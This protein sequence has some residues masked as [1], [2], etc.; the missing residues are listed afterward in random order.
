MGVA[1]PSVSILASWVCGGVA[2]TVRALVSAFLLEGAVQE[3]GGDGSGNRFSA[4]TGSVG[5][6]VEPCNAAASVCRWC[7]VLDV[8]VVRAPLLGVHHTC[9]CPLGSC[10]FLKSSEIL[11]IEKVAFEISYPKIFQSSLHSVILVLDRLKMQ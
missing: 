1:P 5:V 10:G 8:V 9:H 7:P 4:Q 3:A 2:A 6:E 11:E